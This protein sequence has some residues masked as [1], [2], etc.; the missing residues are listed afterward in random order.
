MIHWYRMS[1]VPARFNVTQY[2]LRSA[3][4]KMKSQIGANASEP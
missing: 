4:E 1:Y 2:E 3:Q